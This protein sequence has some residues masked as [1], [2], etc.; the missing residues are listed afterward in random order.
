MSQDTVKD[1]DIPLDPPEDPDIPDELNDR[2]AFSRTLAA[3]GYHNHVVLTRDAGRDALTGKRP[4]LIDYLQTT[5]P[6]S[7]RK[8][9]RDLDRNKSNVSQDLTRLS[10]L[11]IV[12]YIDG[13]H[14]AKAPRLQYDHIII[15]PIA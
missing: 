4:E 13:P 7:V 2:D 9:A 10:E 11:G 6:D 15:E 14:G 5:E 3:N 1:G 8:A 12:T